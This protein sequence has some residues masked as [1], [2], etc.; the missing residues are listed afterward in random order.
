MAVYL[1][2]KL[3]YLLVGGALTI[4]AV[5]IWEIFLRLS[6]KSEGKASGLF[7]TGG[8]A[9]AYLLFYGVGWLILASH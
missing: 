1:P 4:P 9:L 2:E 7:A 8:V 3:V 6:E 5:V